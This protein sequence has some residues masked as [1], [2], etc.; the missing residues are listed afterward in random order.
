MKK[1]LTVLLICALMLPLFAL[2]PHGI[3]VPAEEEVGENEV[4]PLGSANSYWNARRSEF[5]KIADDTV[6]QA[7]FEFFKAVYDPEAIV[8]W[9]V[10]LYDPE[11]GGFYYAISARDTEGFLPD[12]ESTYQICQRL[13]DVSPINH[14][15]DDEKDLRLLLGDTLADKILRFY[16]DKKDTVSGYYYH[17]QWTR[18]VSNAN[19][20]R[21]SRDKDWAGTMI[22]WLTLSGSPSAS[23]V[24][25]T[26][27]RLASNAKLTRFFDDHPWGEDT[28]AAMTAY[29]NNLLATETCESWAN[30][31]ETQKGT[32]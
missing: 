11:E 23:T 12:M 30:T 27:R 16:T 15:C 7:V 22:G 32:L 14:D 6:E 18:E 29:V 2:Y 8:D 1:I 10:D 31:L 24:D 3:S 17:P 5:N 4:R 19:L 25:V 21:R 28:P 26:V 20:M 13:H 9:W